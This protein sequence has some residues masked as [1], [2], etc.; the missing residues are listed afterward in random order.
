MHNFFLYSHLILVTSEKMK[1]S[2]FSK[3]KQD[4]QFNK[5]GDTAVKGDDFK[6]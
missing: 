2:L 3:L 1:E 4:N 5:E 6:F